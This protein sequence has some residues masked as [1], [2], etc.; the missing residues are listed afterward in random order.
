SPHGTARGPPPPGHPL[1]FAKA[2][3]PALNE[4]DVVAVIGTPLDFRL[5]FGE[6][7]AARV[8][9]GAAAPGRRP[10]PVE[11]AP[12]PAGALR[13][14]LT[15]LAGYAGARADHAEWVEGLRAAED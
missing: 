11:P 9:H 6:F 8:V 12:A 5:G 15:G 4:A 1:A 10:A 2:R 3:R 7:P 14:I 13:Q